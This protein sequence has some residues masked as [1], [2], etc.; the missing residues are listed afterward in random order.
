MSLFR[1]TRQEDRISGFLDAIFL[2]CEKSLP[3]TEVY[4]VDVKRETEET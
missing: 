4:E 3:E 2:D 1:I